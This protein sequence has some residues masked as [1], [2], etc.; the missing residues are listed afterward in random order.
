MRGII[1]LFL[2]VAFSLNRSNGVSSPALVWTYNPAELQG[3]S[4]CNVTYFVHNRELCDAALRLGTRYVERGT[5]AAC[6]LIG[7]YKECLAELIQETACANRV[8][9]LDQLKPMRR[10]IQRSH[11]ECSRERKQPR[12]TARVRV[13][14]ES[15]S[16]E[17]K[18][19]LV[20]FLCAEEFQS[21]LRR[22]K[23][24]A[25]VVE[26]RQI[27][28]YLDRYQGCVDAVMHGLPARE[29]PELVAH[30]EYFVGVLT[31]KYRTM[32]FAA[33]QV[34]TAAIARQPQMER[35]RAIFE[36][37]QTPSPDVQ[38]CDLHEHTATFFACGLQFNEVVSYNP[39]K[40]KVCMG[41]YNFDNC[42][43]HVQCQSLSDFYTHSMHVRDVLLQ[44]YEPY[45]QGY[46]PRAIDT[47]IVPLPTPPP[48]QPPTR[49]TKGPTA[50][51][52]RPK[53]PTT[54]PAPVCDEDVYLMGYL[55][56]GLRFAINM[57][58]V[59]VGVDSKYE[60][61]VCRLYRDFL[62]CIKL[63]DP[64]RSAGDIASYLRHFTAVLTEGY[65]KRCRH[66]NVTVPCTKLRLLEAFFSCGLTYYQSRHNSARWYR[67][68]GAGVCEML[69]AFRLCVQTASI[70]C[71]DLAELVAKLHEVVK[72][73]YKKHAPTCLPE[74]G[75][76]DHR[77]RRFMRL[78]WQTSCDQPK[79]VQRPGAV[80]RHLRP[81][82]AVG[83]RQLRQ[84]KRQVGTT[85]YRV[86]VS[87]FP[88]LALLK[89]CR[90]DEAV[91]LCK[92]GREMKHCLR[93]AAD[94][95]GCSDS[96]ILEFEISALQKHLLS[97]FDGQCAATT[98][99]DYATESHGTACKL[100]EFTQDWELCDW[101]MQDYYATPLYRN[102][103]LTRTTRID[104]ASRN[105]LCAELASHRSCLAESA[106]RRHCAGLA[107]QAAALGNRLFQQLDSAYCSG[108]GR[109]E[110]W[111][112][113]MLVTASAMMALQFV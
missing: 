111:L 61:Q 77:R 50:T 87:L 64:C 17:V 88:T 110:L 56:C 21:N 42:T 67:I 93:S 95:S 43:K 103:T 79:A 13:L 36:S 28:R 58:N 74:E 80:W 32:C 8:F 81:H 34:T 57:R 60:C 63:L 105:K 102:G 89:D 11:N 18:A 30:M 54:P 84:C 10:Q 37:E 109:C 83:A 25:P 113:P 104:H 78:D 98:S 100:K 27:C 44:A 24:G 69:D 97:E 6:S 76:Q 62:T 12:P 9:L 106:A 5:K 90:V 33:P 51:S 38:E 59:S 26:T 73:M 92:L 86:P 16:Q 52:R 65:E 94:D 22:G 35:L 4:G 3:G 23:R 7:E 55:D 91:Y 48:V 2:G 14:P 47:N 101:K 53:T 19:W 40:E 68:A 1:G 41:Y 108:C 66:H 96:R 49:T 29:N 75:P 70:G 20:Q 85:I 82:A 45:C 46:V 71:D 39:P 99:A 31:R 107:P 112:V 72:Y 15:T